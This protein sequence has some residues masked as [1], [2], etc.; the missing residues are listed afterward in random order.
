[1]RVVSPVSVVK[2]PQSYCGYSQ[3]MQLDKA[4]PLDKSEDKRKDEIV[5]QDPQDFTPTQ[6]SCNCS[7]RYRPTSPIMY[8]NFSMGL[9][10]ETV[11]IHN[12]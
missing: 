12:F 9:K 7:T 11:I 1:M 2:T 4:K 6:T 5:F 3:N 8:V 10:H